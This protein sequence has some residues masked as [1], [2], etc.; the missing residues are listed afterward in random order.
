MQEAERQI[1]GYRDAE[2]KHQLER[3]EFEKQAQKQTQNLAQIHQE[4]V[5]TEDLLNQL[6]EENQELKKMVV[7]LQRENKALKEQLREFQ[8]GVASAI[9]EAKAKDAALNGGN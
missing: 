7:L 1:E 5:K 4:L 6:R 2:E 3:E 9:G 8:S